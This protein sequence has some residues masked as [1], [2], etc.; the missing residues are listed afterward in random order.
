MAYDVFISHSSQDKVTA[1]AVCGT[2]EANGI[3]CWIAPRDI[4][5]G[6]EY[7]SEIISAIKRSRVMVVLFSEAANGSRHVKRE[8]ERA[9]SHGVTLIPFRIED[10][11]PD[12]SL[13]YFIGSIHWLDA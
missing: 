11:V 4:T 8:V 5:G 13:E 1:D 12:S 3:K 2:L 9:V 6:E 7:G 10:V